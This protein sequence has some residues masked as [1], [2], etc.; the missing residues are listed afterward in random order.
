[1]DEHKVFVADFLIVAR[2]RCFVFMKMETAFLNGRGQ[3]FGL[4][5]V[6]TRKM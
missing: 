2:S 6:K 3:W 5:E 4:F 1:M